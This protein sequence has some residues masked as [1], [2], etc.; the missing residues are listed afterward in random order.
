VR[1]I[2]AGHL[3]RHYTGVELRPEQVA[4]NEAQAKVIKTKAPA[5]WVRGDSADMASL[6][7][8]E[9]D[10]MFTCPPYGDL[11]VY[12]D[13][14]ADISSMDYP[15]FIVA[16]RK[17]FALTVARLRADRFAAVVVGDF[18]NKKGFY[19]NFVSDT[20][21]AMQDAGAGLYNEAILV[22]AVG[23][24]SIRAGRQFS[25]GRKLGKAL[26]N[27]TPVLTPRGWE[28][29]EDLELGDEV[30][31][32]DGSRTTVT[33]VFPQGERPLFTVR[34]CDGTEV[35]ADADHL[36]RVE[37]RDD[38]PVTMTTAQILERFGHEPADPRPMIPLCGPVELDATPVPVDPYLVGLLLGD[39]GLTG[40]TPILSSADPE[41]VDRLPSLLPPGMVIKGRGYDYRL[42]GDGP[43]NKA[44]PLA[45][46]LRG[47]GMMGRM[48]YEKEVPPLYLWNDSEVRLAVLRGLMD[49]DGCVSG[50]NA[51]TE[52]QSSSRRLADDVA[53]L[54]R[55]LGMRASWSERATAS[56]RP[57][58]RIRLRGDVC[59]F[60]LKRKADI[61]RAADVKRTHRKERRIESI[62]PAEP[63]QATC[64]AVAHPSRLFVTRDFIVTHN[65]HQQLLV[66]CKGDPKKA[67]EACG[68][69]DVAETPE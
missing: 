56:G 18:R 64:I 34:F 14:P 9:F 8:G 40:T 66:F 62:L 50:R 25:A 23:S 30:I 59:P 41:T 11:E 55:S 44:N 1:G 27:G 46:L 3:G 65:T 6:V 12:S 7:K 29:I 35:D 36:W 5:K 31:A 15:E 69:V 38:D 51:T 28:A 49:T 19:R 4:A 16:L 39:G 32:G 26:R 58:Y 61:W 67:T 10:F 33:G 24:L 22:T 68:P 21:A 43:R 54:A 53:F 2:V 63:G 57:A 17:I 37:C 13:D 60:L 20:I 47:L 52:F 48:S 45:I 42:V